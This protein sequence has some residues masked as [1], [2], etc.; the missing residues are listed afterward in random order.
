MRYKFYNKLFTIIFSLMLFSGCDKYLDII[1][2]GSVI[3][4]TAQEFRKML[5]HAYS[6]I[7]E[8]RVLATLRA[9]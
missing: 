3:I 2:T 8:D 5:T 9:D 7:P 4:T 1:P 6:I